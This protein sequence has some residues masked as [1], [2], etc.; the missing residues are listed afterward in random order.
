MTISSELWG[1]SRI[2]RISRALDLTDEQVDAI[3]DDLRRG[4]VEPGW[5]YGSATSINPLVVVL[6]ASPGTS[7][8]RGDRNYEKRTHSTSLRQECSE[9]FWMDSRP[10]G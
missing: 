10:A 5:P 1:A 2:D 3:H 9:R 8:Q 6:G 4:R 7:P